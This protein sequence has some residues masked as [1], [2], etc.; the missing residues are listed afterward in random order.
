[1]KEAY[2]ENTNSGARHCR[3]RV[4]FNVTGRRFTSV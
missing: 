2:T 4:R 3:L 1:M